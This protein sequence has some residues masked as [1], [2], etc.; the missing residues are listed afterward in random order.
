MW[1]EC[2]VCWAPCW[3]HEM[4]DGMCKHCAKEPPSHLR[5]TKENAMAEHMTAGELL[6]NIEKGMNEMKVKMD[7]M[8]LV[9]ITSIQDDHAEATTYSVRKGV[10]FDWDGALELIVGEFVTG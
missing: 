10:W 8:V 2:K 7:D 1:S 4:Q 3:T 6:A 5:N 9:T